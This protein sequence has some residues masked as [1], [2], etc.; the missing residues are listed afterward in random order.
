MIGGLEE[1]VWE[2]LRSSYSTQSAHTHT[3]AATVHIRS[4]RTQQF[5]S[6]KNHDALCVNCRKIKLKKTYIKKFW[7]TVDNMRKALQGKEKSPHN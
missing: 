7:T 5:R 6:V 1:S 2:I 4:N 3:K